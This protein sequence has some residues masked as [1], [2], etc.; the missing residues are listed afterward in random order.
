MYWPFEASDETFAV[1]D[2]TEDVAG[3]F[4]KLRLTATNFE[5][6]REIYGTSTVVAL[7]DFRIQTQMPGDNDYVCED[8]SVKDTH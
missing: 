2:A 5:G 7:D 1:R 8:L 6:M 3:R 4:Y